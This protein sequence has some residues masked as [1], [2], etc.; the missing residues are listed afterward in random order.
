M[1]SWLYHLRHNCHGSLYMMAAEA[2][3]AA[4]ASVN[5]VFAMDA[6]AA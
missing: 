4:E 6:G 3:E 1:V 5:P 2:A